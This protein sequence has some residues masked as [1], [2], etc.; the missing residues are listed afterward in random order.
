VAKLSLLCVFVGLLLSGLLGGCSPAV[1][2]ASEAVIA[3]ASAAVAMPDT[4]AADITA[5]VLMAGGN[6]V[7]AAVAAAFSLAVTYP[8][9]GNIGV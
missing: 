5:D 1:Q 7:D 6:A 9:A 3:P 2:S 8:E 4:F